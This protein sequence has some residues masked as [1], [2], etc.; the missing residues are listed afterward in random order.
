MINIK[1]M[2]TKWF[3]ITA[4]VISILGLIG[5][6]LFAVPETATLPGVS[7]YSSYLI[8][9]IFAFH[10]YFYGKELIQKNYNKEEEK[11]K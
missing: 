9:S 5:T 10:I 1:F 11:T 4:F 3:C 2:K 6:L 8:A 7:K